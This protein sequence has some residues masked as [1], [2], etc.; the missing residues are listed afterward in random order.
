LEIFLG[1]AMA[2]LIRP[3]KSEVKWHNFAAKSLVLSAKQRI[4]RIGQIEKR[5]TAGRIRP[6]ADLWP[7]GAQTY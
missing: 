3:E 7:V 6:G 5:P 4:T 2:S 1:G